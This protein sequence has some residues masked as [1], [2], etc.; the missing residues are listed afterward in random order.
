[1][2]TKQC[3]FR[4]AHRCAGNDPRGTIRDRKG[5]VFP[6]WSVCGLCYNVIW[7]S[8]PLSL[9]SE[10]KTVR[11]LGFGAV[12]L[13]FTTETG[14]ETAGI[15]RDFTD[16]YRNGRAVSDGRDHTRGHFRRGVE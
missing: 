3:L 2:V 11:S 1:M 6:V 14:T 9:L 4:N 10:W 8:V 16:A 12:R 15:I 5:V 13:M 7:N